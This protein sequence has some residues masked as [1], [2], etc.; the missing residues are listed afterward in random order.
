M[1]LIYGRFR[2]CGGDHVLQDRSISWT[3]LKDA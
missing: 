1:T 3:R 2:D